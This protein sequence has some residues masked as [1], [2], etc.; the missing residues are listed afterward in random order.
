[1]AMGLVTLFL[2]E[3]APKK[4]DAAPSD[5]VAGLALLLLAQNTPTRLFMTPRT[6]PAR[7]SS[8]S[9]LYVHVHIY[10]I[11]M[12]DILSLSSFSGSDTR[13]PELRARPV[14]DFSTHDCCRLG[15]VLVSFT[16]MFAAAR[17]YRGQVPLDHVAVREFQFLVEEKESGQHDGSLKINAAY[18]LSPV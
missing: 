6:L 10:G 8:P 15:E 2:S 16:L 14:V 3:T 1:M 4:A 18:K 9:W 11:C 12:D 7:A 17:L 13:W 5:V